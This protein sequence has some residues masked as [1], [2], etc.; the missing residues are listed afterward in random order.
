VFEINQKKA[1]DLRVEGLIPAEGVPPEDLPGRYWVA[2]F[3]T[4]TPS[5]RNFV[6]KFVQS[7]IGHP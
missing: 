4:T 5:G 7:Q 3:S 2:Q 1:F 6:P